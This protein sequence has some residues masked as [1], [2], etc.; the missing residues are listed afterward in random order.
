MTLNHIALQNL[1]RRPGKTLFLVL[2]FAFI[3]ATISALTILALGMK[4]DLQQSLTEYGANVVVSPRT[5]QL[6]L[7]YGGLS[8]SSVEYEVKKLDSSTVKIIS[9]QVG[10]TVTIA[11]KVIG[12]IQSPEKLYMIVGVDFDQE[13]KIKP[14]WKID[15]KVPKENEIVLGSQLA[16]SANLHIGDIMHFGKAKYPVIGILAET[17]GSEDQGVFATIDTARS[18]TGITTEW[19]LIEL[20][21]QDT[22]QTAA[23]LAPVLPE[24]NVTEVTQLVQGSKD[25]VERFAS[26]SWTISIAMGLIGALVI[27]VTLAGN[28]NDRARELGVLRAIGFRQNHILNLFGREALII[29]LTGSLLGYIIG[30]FVPLI[31]GPLLGYNSFIFSTHLGLGSAL[32][33]ASLLVGM[34]AMIYPAWR[35]LKLD[36]QDVLKFI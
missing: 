35:T 3:V 28:V 2:T 24:A 21:T 16:M 31:V 6:N 32:V 17:G 1:R 18:L 13:L 4:E 27:I 19:S 15:G 5:E 34:V 33:A 11:P 22:A 30:I 7:S 20:N 36:L 23:Q 8:V 14:W 10:E 25:S 26:F 9:K 12:S 29:S